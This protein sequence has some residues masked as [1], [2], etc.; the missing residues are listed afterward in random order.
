MRKKGGSFCLSIHLSVS[1]SIL[2]SFFLSITLGRTRSQPAR[3]RVPPGSWEKVGDLY[4]KPIM[5]LTF[6]RPWGLQHRC[7]YLESS[8]QLS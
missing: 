8:L 4:C 2:L 7:N 5:A 1:L 3:W 6:I